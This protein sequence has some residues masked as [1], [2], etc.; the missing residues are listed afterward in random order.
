[1]KNE[2]YDII[3]IGGGP[4]GM[5]AAGRAGELG[6]K[7]LLLEKN[8]RLG[9]KL[10]LTGGGRCNITNA[11]FDVRLFLDH[12]PE[13][14][15]FL[16]SPFAQFAVR[17]TFDFFEKLNLPLVVEER[18]R[19]FPKVQKAESVCHVL[20]Q[21]LK[22]SGNV[23]ICFGEPAESLIMK[24]QQVVGVKTEQ[25]KYLAKKIILATGGL[26]LPETGSTGDGLKMSAKLGHTI[27][28]PDP[29]LAPL[30]SPDKWVHELAG[31]SLEPI[32][33][34]FTQNKQ[35]NI[36]E[37][38]R[39]LFTHFGISGP[40]VINLSHQV[41]ELLKK[42]KV[43][44]ALDLFPDH[45]LGELNTLLVDLFEANKNRLVKNILS[46][47]FSKKLVPVI[48]QK[49]GVKLGDKKVH[50]V[51]K[52]ER[53][54]LVD[55]LKD[56]HFVIDGTMGLDWSIV[57]DGGVMPKEID[58]KTMSSKLHPNLYLIGDVVNINRPSGGFSLQ[59]CWTT[60]WV[61]GTHAAQNL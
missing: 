45:N 6:A 43:Q 47:L 26:A 59:L 36:K 49:I 11:E 3:V 61:A 31:L 39:V 8:Q 56:L 55:L 18:Q 37:T 9:K 32:T 28:E 34:R 53:K 1:M 35:T 2:T 51:T 38:G 7:V 30:R 20:A 22:Q 19:A 21:Y 58:F 41:Q 54:M 17:D 5:M 13:S 57:A 27:A 29:N 4:A 23:T 10:S 33:L 24:D 52:E 50:S 60:G 14:K 15:K 48:L 25:S 44:A 12:F 16:F 40:M 46:E 42:G